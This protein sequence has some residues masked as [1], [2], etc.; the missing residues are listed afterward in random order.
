M[1]S[2][3]RKPY[4]TATVLNQAFL[5]EAH[6][7]LVNQLELI[8]DIEAPDGSIIYASD[9]HKF[10]GGTFYEAL[11]TFPVIERTLGE[12]LVGEI[13]FSELR[14]SLSNADGRFNKFLPTGSDFQSWV[15]NSVEVKLGLRDV[16]STYF[17]IF[18]GRVTQV[19]GFGRST[20]SIEITA[21][22]EYD[23]L[24]VSIP[25]TI[26]GRTAYPKI[27]G[28]IAG[29]F[30]PLVYGDW[31][32][33]V[34]GPQ[35]SVPAFI[36]NGLDPLVERDLARNF[37]L[38][39]GSPDTFTLENHFFE[40][41]DKV[42]LETDGTLASGYAV[43]TDYYVI[44]I[45]VNTFGLSA[46]SGPG[47]AIS[48]VGAGTGQARIK[49]APTATI[50]NVQLRI[51][52]NDLSF[53]DTAQVWLKRGDNQ[54]KID[55]ADVVSVGAGN[56]TFD[57]V[58]NSGLTLV[59]A[60]ANYLYKSGD[61]FFVRV[62]GKDLGA[63]D[64]NLVSQARDLLLTYGGIVSGDLD[65][66]WDTYRDKTTPAESALANIKSRVWLQDQQSLIAY[67]L[68]MF[69]QVRLELFST[70]ELKLKLSSLH[71]EDFTAKLSSAPITIKNWDVERS[72]LKLAI[73]DRNNFNRIKGAYAFLP[74]VK[75]NGFAT[76]IWKNTLNIS[77]VGREISKQIAFPNL[78]VDSDVV[79]QIKE[80]LRLSSGFFEIVS[81]SLTWRSLL[82]E[83]GD[84]VKCNV[85]IGSAQFSDVPFL[86]RSVGYEPQGLKL[87]VQFWSL[88]MIP[89]SG[90]TPG[91]AGISGGTSAVL[92]QE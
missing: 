24:S 62:K 87:S 67:V 83:P 58:Q 78:Y 46:T 64:D 69:E 25:T 86:L 75:E 43:S 76:R 19:G 42:Q 59:E 53:L 8:C 72:S 90:W 92:V 1:G 88:Q 23:K 77:Q 13:T 65:A 30:M 82:L 44:P 71:L 34:S 22:D 11:L 45:S 28:E 6:D 5:D 29:L 20:F 41:N 49:G 84:I 3:T 61:L 81:C 31:T 10:V 54:F 15:G 35:G 38:A 21:R 89:F 14:I 60:G 7:S 36:L 80:V 27:E 26:F 57:V 70:R 32:T 17:R 40:S 55:T 85:Q 37:T 79:N 68:S 56:K 50:R 12:W 91:Y 51:S 2:Q 48:S 4:L 73:D 66:N 39:I 33:Q 74:D 63:Y 18:R 52:D 9:R 16:E 47:S